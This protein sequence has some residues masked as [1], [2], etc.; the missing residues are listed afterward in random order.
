MHADWLVARVF[1][2]PS[3]PRIY[4]FLFRSAHKNGWGFALVAAHKGQRDDSI[5]CSDV[6]PILIIK[7]NEQDAAKGIGQGPAAQ[8]VLQNGA[9][10]VREDQGNGIGRVQ[11]EGVVGY[12]SQP[13]HLLPVSGTA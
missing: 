7:N 11:S 1:D 4:S 12:S 13:S 2:L 10:E 3:K 9:A 5:D 8:G 6:E